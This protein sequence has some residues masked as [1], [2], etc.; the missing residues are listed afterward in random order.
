MA[1]DVLEREDIH[2]RFL[3]NM[4]GNKKKYD[5]KTCYI[6]YDETVDCECETI[7][8][9]KY[10]SYPIELIT[11]I[12]KYD[13][14]SIDTFKK[15]HNLVFY[16]DNN[17]FLYT[18]NETQGIHITISHPRQNQ[19]KFLQFFWYFE[20][21]I[22]RFL[23]PYRQNIILETATPLR[24]QFP[25]F[26][27]I[28]RPK[29]KYSS[30]NMRE[31]SFEIRIIDPDQ[32]YYEHIYTYIYWVNL[33]I[34]LLWCSIKKSVNKIMPNPDKP[35]SELELFDE[36]FDM[37][38]DSENIGLNDMTSLRDYFRKRYEIYN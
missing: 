14:E 17:N 13:K 38:G 2:H 11:P 1:N 28:D 31:N 36:L 18:F 22:I 24:I 5:F 16:G 12:I 33:L 34:K 15:I 6:D 30:V 26:G 21:I 37:L 10:T 27:E 3:V 20:P 29:L 35:I 19:L 8:G 7:E 4:E 25:T 9:L 32:I 23:P